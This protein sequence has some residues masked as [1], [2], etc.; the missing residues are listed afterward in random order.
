MEISSETGISLHFSHMKGEIIKTFQRQCIL[1]LSGRAI[2][3]AVSITGEG[4]QNSMAEHCRDQRM[5]RLF[6]AVYFQ[7]PAFFFCS[8][9]TTLESRIKPMAALM[10][11]K[12]ISRLIW[13]DMLTQ[14]MT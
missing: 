13:E 5:S 9:F 4:W 12:L 14:N 1:P 6:L 8:F 7:N 11:V 3:F 10:Y 2:H